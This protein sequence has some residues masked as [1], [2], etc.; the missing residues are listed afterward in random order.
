MIQNA[1]K[2]LLNK[3]NPTDI[4]CAIISLGDYTSEKDAIVYLLKENYS[5]EELKAF[6]KSLDFMYNDGYGGQELYGTVWLKDSTW[7]AR[8]EYDG[9]EWWVHHSLP[10][11][12]NLLK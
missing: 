9:S 11:V 12:P 3:L 2:E 4:K 8:G 6:F 7:L 5:E 1:R 10:E